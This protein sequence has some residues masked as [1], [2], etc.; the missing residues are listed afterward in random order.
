MEC[1]RIDAGFSC[2][3]LAR[4]CSLPEYPAPTHRLAAGGGK[5][6]G[7]MFEDDA[8][9]VWEALRDL[10]EADD[11]DELLER[12]W[13]RAPFKA[14]S[15]YAARLRDGGKDPEDWSAPRDFD[16]GLLTSS[17]RTVHTELSQRRFAETKQGDT[18]PVS[19]FLKLDP[20][21]ICN[22]LRAGTAS[23]RGAFTSPRPIHPFS[24]RRITVRE[25]ARIHPT[26]TG[27]G[28]T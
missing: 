22:T 23:D 14:P 11:Y 9:T 19:R 20:G 8:P 27:S 1:H 2:S 13:V 12:D 25:A 17:L 18:E 28:S 7:H 26:R 5:N 4:E 24:P 16:S 6:G 10:P 21:G 15:A 3:G